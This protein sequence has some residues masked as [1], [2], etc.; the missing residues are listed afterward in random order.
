MLK[1]VNKAVYS[2]LHDQLAKTLNSAKRGLSGP[3]ICSLC[4]HSFKTKLLLFGYDFTS[5]NHLLMSIYYLHNH[6]QV[7]ILYSVRERW[8]ETPGRFRHSL[9]EGTIDIKYSKYPL[10]TTGNNSTFECIVIQVWSRISYRM[11]WVN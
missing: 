10:Y 8:K 1:S 11:R 7:V 2:D 9:A 6:I 3:E 4:R 5:P